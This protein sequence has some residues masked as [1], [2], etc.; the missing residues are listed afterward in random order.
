MLRLENGEIHGSDDGGYV[1]NTELVHKQEQKDGNGKNT[2]GMKRFRPTGENLIV[3]LTVIGE[4]ILFINI[5]F[6][7]W[8][9]G[10]RSIHGHFFK[11]YFFICSPAGHFYP[12]VPTRLALSKCL[13]GQSSKN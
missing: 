1:S 10:G 9:N 8:R 13:Y 2:N 3:V 11:Q 7:K 4:N 12:V 5:A 6:R